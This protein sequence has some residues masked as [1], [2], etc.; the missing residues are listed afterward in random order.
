MHYKF[1]WC[2]SGVCVL[3][4][5]IIETSPQYTRPLHIGGGVSQQ[6]KLNF[7]DDRKFENLMKSD[8]PVNRVSIDTG[9]LDIFSREFTNLFSK[10]QTSIWNN[11]SDVSECESGCLYGESGRLRDGSTGLKTFRRTC[12]EYR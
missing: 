1:Q 6:E 7:V 5:T 9:E 3:R 10:L 11:W 12:R 8:Y 2:R 4:T